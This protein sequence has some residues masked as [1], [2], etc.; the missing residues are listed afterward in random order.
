MMRG[1]E[2]DALQLLCDL[3]ADTYT[4]L[5]QSPV[6]SV[7]SAGFFCRLAEPNRRGLP[8]QRDLA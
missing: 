4:E 6:A 8:P 5:A 3:I 1:A 2:L 7:K